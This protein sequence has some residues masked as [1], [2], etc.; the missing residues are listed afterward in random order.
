[1][2][3]SVDACPNGH[4]DE[5]VGNDF[6][7]TDLDLDC[8]DFEMIPETRTFSTASQSE[9]VVVAMEHGHRLVAA[10]VEW[11]P[12]SGSV[13]LTM[14]CD[15]GL[16]YPQARSLLCDGLAKART[17]KPADPERGYLALGP[18]FTDGRAFAVRLSKALADGAASIYEA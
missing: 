1:V 16:G 14:E 10:T 12:A 3:F 5:F 8:L 18:Q 6:A 7:N 2:H 4:Y 11:Y 9:R 13:F 17:A 15:A